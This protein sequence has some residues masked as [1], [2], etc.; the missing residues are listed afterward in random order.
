M[1]SIILFTETAESRLQDV[2][3]D[4]V[5][6]SLTDQTL[7]GDCVVHLGVELGLSIGNIKEAMFNFP[8][9][10]NGQIHAILTKWKDRNNTNRP[11]PTIY[12]LMVALKRIEAAE[13]LFFVKKAYN[14]K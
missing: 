9:D 7:I 14:I 11:I 8:R 12:R 10:L 1:N 6:N 5:I 13:G 4:H 2:P 3:S